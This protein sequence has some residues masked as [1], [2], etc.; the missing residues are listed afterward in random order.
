MHMSAYA[1][2]LDVNMILLLWIAT[3]SL[4]NIFL[5]YSLVLISFLSSLFHFLQVLHQFSFSN[6]PLL[7]YIQHCSLI[8]TTLFR[9]CSYFFLLLLFS[10][11]NLTYGFNHCHW[12]N[13]NIQCIYLVLN[14]IFS[15]IVVFIIKHILF[16]IKRCRH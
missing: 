11:L 5:T 1:G 14:L 15:K 3:K 4:S 16:F 7:Y 9:L 10:V 2:L 12:I 6:F 8:H 13:S